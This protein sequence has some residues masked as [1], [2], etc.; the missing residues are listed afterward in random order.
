MIDAAQPEFAAFHTLR[1][2]SRRDHF[3]R[4]FQLG[5]IGVGRK[6][7]Q[8]AATSPTPI[9]LEPGDKSP[10]VLIPDNPQDKTARSIVLGKFTNAGQTCNAP[11][12]ISRSGL[13]ASIS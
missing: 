1:E 3:A 12:P 9:T 8:A 10:A 13:V 6:V 11:H 5:S 2:A 4:Y 7:M